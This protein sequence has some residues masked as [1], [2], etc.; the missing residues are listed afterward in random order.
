MENFDAYQEQ[1]FYTNNTGH[2]VCAYLGHQKG[3]KYIWETIRDQE[4]KKIARGAMM[5]TGQALVKKYH[6]KMDEQE[7]FIDEFLFRLD[8][9]ALGD[10]T[11]RVRRDPIRK[12]SPQERLVGAAKFAEKYGI[13]P[14]N[15]CIEIATAFKSMIK[16]DK[17]SKKLAKYLKENGMDW[18]L[19]TICR[20]DTQRSLTK[21]IKQSL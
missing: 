19:K 7:R 9:P 6:F 1:K 11:D 3:Y 17:E 10:T 20:V 5:E 12:L 21:L 4:V 18:V 2:A 16:G 15:L 14:T 13:V 8:N